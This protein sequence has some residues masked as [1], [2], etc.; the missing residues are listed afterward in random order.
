MDK[1]KKNLK[2]ARD[3]HKVYEN[4]NRNP[5]KISLKLGSCTKMAARFYGPFEILDRI[6]PVAYILHCRLP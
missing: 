2:A 4:K 6:G 3:R 1:I 5:K